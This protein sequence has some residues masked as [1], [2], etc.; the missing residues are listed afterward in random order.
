MLYHLQ[1]LAKAWGP[2]R[3]FSSH[4]FLASF[5]A[6][7]AA[8]LVGLLL[9][10]LWNLLPRDRGKALVKEGAA[11]AGKNHSFHIVLFSIYGNTARR[12]S[13]VCFYTSLSKTAVT[14]DSSNANGTKRIVGNCA[15][16]DSRCSAGTYRSI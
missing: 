15:H 4:T 1:F 12:N 3:L 7:L 14:P 16:S 11:S 2:L 8:L 5:G 6:A 9:P 13:A 10:R